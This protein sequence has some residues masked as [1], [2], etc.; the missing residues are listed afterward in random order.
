MEGA[1]TI[2]APLGD[3]VFGGITA[4]RETTQV[5]IRSHAVA[6]R[7]NAIMRGARR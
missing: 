3:G 5:R 1:G 2:F 6:G 7:L 4:G